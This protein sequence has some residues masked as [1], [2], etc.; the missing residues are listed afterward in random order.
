MWV[1]IHETDQ[2]AI[3]GADHR[4]QAR[5]CGLF[6]ATADELLSDTRFTLRRELFLLSFPRCIVL[7]PFAMRMPE[8]KAVDIAFAPVT[9]DHFFSDGDYALIPIYIHV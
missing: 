2:A 6:S 8:H 3:C 4:T 1:A 9:Q 7:Q 5:Y